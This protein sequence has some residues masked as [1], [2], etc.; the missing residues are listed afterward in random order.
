MTSNRLRSFAPTQPSEARQ[1]ARVAPGDRVLPAARC[2]Q[3]PAAP[4]ARLPTGRPAR[5]RRALAPHAYRPRTRPE[6]SRAARLGPRR[7]VRAG[8]RPESRRPRPGW[9]AQTAPPSRPHH[10]ARRSPCERK[11]PVKRDSVPTRSNYFPILNSSCSSPENVQTLDE[12]VLK[13]IRTGWPPKILCV[14]FVSKKQGIIINYLTRFVTV[15]T[16]LALGGCISL[17]AGP[18]GQQDA[19]GDT[20][21]A[22]YDGANGATGDTGAPGYNGSTGTTRA[23]GN[24][25]ARRNTDRKG[26]TGDTA[27]VVPPTTR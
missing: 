2:M 22:G 10:G 13:T 14:F 8:S 18:A 11:H 26:T 3:T 7:Y 20:G 15:S 4:H 1:R 19:T 6:W 24:T 9:R 21:A 12:A 16:A 5:A 17:P 23:N 27:I 25:G